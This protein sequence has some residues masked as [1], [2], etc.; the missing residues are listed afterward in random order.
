MRQDIGYLYDIDI[1]L[2]SVNYKSLQIQLSF[3]VDGYNHQRE[4]FQ[5]EETGDEEHI[6]VEDRRIKFL[7]T[8]FMK[9]RSM[10]KTTTAIPWSDFYFETSLTNLGSNSVAIG[11]TTH[12]PGT[13]SLRFP[14]KIPKTIGL[15]V[16]DKSSELYHGGPSLFE[17]GIDP[18]S[19]HDILGCKVEL[20]EC[21]RARHRLCSFTINGKPAGSPRYLEDIELFPT[22]M[23]DSPG[24]ILETNFGDKKFIHEPKGI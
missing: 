15:A 20:I 16:D 18:V 11:L 7:G 23:I 6:E 21:D 13:R 4:Y 5:W 17:E 1:M 22:I 12:I 19:S 8:E 2:Y 24:A 10:I 9:H 3:I 14:G